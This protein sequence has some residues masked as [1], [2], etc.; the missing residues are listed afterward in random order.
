MVDP[1]T[2]VTLGKL[3][4]IDYILTGEIID[5]GREVRSFSGYGVRTDTVFYRLEAVV[6]ILERETGRIVFSK[7]ERAEERQNQ[8][9]GMRVSDTTIDARLG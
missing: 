3:S 7:T 4:G 6:R 8:G 5:F 2:A 1:A 9:A